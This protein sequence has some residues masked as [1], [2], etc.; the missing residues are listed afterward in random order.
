MPQPHCRVVRVRMFRFL[1][2]AAEVRSVGVDWDHLSG[3]SQ[4]KVVEKKPESG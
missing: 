4:L 3:P 1:R 2:E